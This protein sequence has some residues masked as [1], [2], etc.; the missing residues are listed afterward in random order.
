MGQ[1]EEVPVAGQQWGDMEA[2][3]DDRQ[4]RKVQGHSEGPPPPGKA[5]AK[6]RFVWLYHGRVGPGP[7]WRAAGV[8]R[9]TSAPGD[10]FGH[11]LA[12]QTRS[13]PSRTLSNDPVP[14]YPFRQRDFDGEESSRPPGR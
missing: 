4:L 3:I 11:S 12:H 6:S 14:R 9:R 8:W 1:H 7:R 2:V 13:C 5:P 10:Q